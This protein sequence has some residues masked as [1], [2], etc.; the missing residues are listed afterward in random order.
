MAESSGEVIGRYT[1]EREI[2]RGGMA[3]VYL[4]HDPQ[5]GRPVAIKL[6][7]K[8]AFPPD[9]MALLL[10]RFQ[11]EAKALGRLNHPSI[12]KV[13]DYGEFR[14]APYLVMEYLKGAT[15]KEV[16]KPIK[17]DV[18]VRLLRPIAE[19]LDYIHRQGILH[20]DI[21][22][23]NLMFDGQDR[24]L[25]TDF[26]IAKWLDDD[27]EQRTLTETGMGIGTPEY[28]APEQGLGQNVD[29]RADFYALAVVFYELI[30][31]VKPYRGET[32]FA[33]MMKHVNDPIPDP[34]AIVPELNESVTRFMRMAM[35][36]EPADRYATP[37]DFL[38]DFD[39]LALQAKADRALGLTSSRVEVNSEKG[40]LENGLPVKDSP[41]EQEAHQ[42]ETPISPRIFQAD[43]RR[44]V[45]AEEQRTIEATEQR[46]IEADERRLPEVTKQ[47]GKKAHEPITV[48]LPDPP[49]RKSRRAKPIRKIVVIL[50]L[51][52]A[53][54]LV[55]PLLYSYLVKVS[56]DAPDYSANDSGT[57]TWMLNRAN[58][59]DFI[60]PTTAA[61]HS[62]DDAPVVD[63]TGTIA[64]TS[65]A[66]PSW[67]W[68]KIDHMYGSC[69]DKVKNLDGGFSTAM[70][71]GTVVFTP[72]LAV[73]GTELEASISPNAFGADSTRMECKW[74]NG[75]L[76]CGSFS[77]TQIKPDQEITVTV[78]AAG[79]DCVGTT[80]TINQNLLNS[81]WSS[82]GE[83]NQFQ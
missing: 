55:L 50:I 41:P 58:P 53:V 27:E 4:A 6:I 9:H 57:P 76:H 20:R 64:L 36:K 7:R 60:R 66:C 48:S 45:E 23:S 72:P 18:A 3:I 61:N 35:A 33:T 28:I 78:Y 54:F 51:I 1:V 13:L 77:F 30:T 21:K 31:G 16:K 62:F 24:V 22:P 47:N 83:C 71:G 8:G 56:D 11:R 43:E 70:I 65:T 12:V 79:T 42:D 10:E 75:R 46:T 67:N 34:R 38:R 73:N 80:G 81:A 32:P 2:G 5:L 52:F 14:G 17:V 37:Q 40:E 25:L 49:I 63:S 39:G 59:N 69:I 19:A 68:V 15:L 29:G 82:L 44:T 74:I 26:G